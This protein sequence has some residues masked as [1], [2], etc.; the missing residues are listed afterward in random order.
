MEQNKPDCSKHKKEVAGISDMKEIA[1]MVGDLHYE[2]L[3]KFIKELRHKIY[4]DG[5]KDF[6][7]GRTQLSSALFEAAINL[8]QVFINIKKAWKISEQFMGTKKDNDGKN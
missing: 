5:Q 3:A 8:H 7:N 2:T 1:E 6:V 4:E